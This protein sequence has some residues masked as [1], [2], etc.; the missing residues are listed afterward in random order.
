[1]RQ[2]GRERRRPEDSL[3][4]TF[5][6]VVGHLERIQEKEER[7]DKWVF[8]ETT[9]FFISN[10]PEKHSVEE[11][12]EAE[13]EKGKEKNGGAPERKM[14][15]KDSGLRKNNVSFVEVVK[16]L[17]SDKVVDQEKIKVIVPK[18]GDQKER[19]I[20]ISVAEV[21]KDVKN[22]KEKLVGEV[23]FHC[24]SPY[25]DQVRKV[26]SDE[27]DEEEED[28]RS[29]SSDENFSEDFSIGE[30]EESFGD[31][32]VQELVPR[33]VVEGSSE[34]SSSPLS[35]KEKKSSSLIQLGCDVD[36]YPAIIDQKQSE[37][38][39]DG[40]KADNMGEGMNVDASLVNIPQV[41]KIPEIL[42]GVSDKLKI[43]LSR[44]TPLK[45]RLMKATKKKK[46]KYRC[47]KGKSETAN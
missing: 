20:D 10:L 37:P 34:K 22:L 4:R 3:Q 36:P 12:R 1:M 38:K 31:S 30:E 24:V 46:K 27:E 11:I 21:E 8:K 16:G 19:R 32:M 35:D 40:L 28:D 9:S 2:G 44:N 25:E 45:T 33:G 7:R 41:E 13:E 26:N 6:W 47:N 5:R 23:F 17:S 15:D 18:E 42:K 29:R 43:L 14:F 39:E